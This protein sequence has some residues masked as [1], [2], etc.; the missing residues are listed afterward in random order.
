M[1]ATNDK[2][3]KPKVHMTVEPSEG[4]SWVFHVSS[5]HGEAPY[6]VDLESYPI[7]VLR[8][9]QWHREFVGECACPDFC[10]RKRKLVEAGQ[11]VRCKHINAALLYIAG[12]A[13]WEAVAAQ[14]K[15]QAHLRLVKSIA[16]TA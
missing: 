4:E 13:V 1:P 10:K 12:R 2:P 5:E 14:R 16:C 3:D 6:R 7:R 9:G 15:R 8:G 11:L